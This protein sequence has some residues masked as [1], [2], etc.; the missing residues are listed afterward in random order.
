MRNQGADHKHQKH[1]QG[2]A[3]V[4]V[5]QSNQKQRD[6]QQRDTDGCEY[7]HCH[8]SGGRRHQLARR[9]VEPGQSRYRLTRDRGSSDHRHV[10]DLLSNQPNGR[11]SELDLDHVGAID[12]IAHADRKA[13]G[14]RRWRAERS[15]L[16][17]RH[18]HGFNAIRGYRAD[19]KINLEL[20]PVDRRRLRGRRCAAGG[21]ILIRIEVQGEFRSVARR[22]EQHEEKCQEEFTRRRTRPPAREEM[23]YVQHH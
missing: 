11:E 19:G 16:A 3:C 7:G 2:R 23:P 4:R 18:H 13:G 17:F 6:G 21:E 1:R 9:Q 15:R 5:A 12:S 14:L 8:W 20:H 10:D 22:C